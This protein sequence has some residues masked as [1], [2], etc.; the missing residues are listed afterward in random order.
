M[1][2]PTRL[3]RIPEREQV[4]RVPRSLGD[5]RFEVDA[6]WGTVGP[7]ELAPGVRTIGECEL[8][9]HLERGLPVMDTRQ[10]ELHREATIAGAHGIPHEEIVTRMGELDPSTP[11]VFFCNGPQCTATPHAVKALLEAG[12]PAE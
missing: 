9:E 2:T 6:T 12:F 1:R 10:A 3:E 11:T 8:I 5:G 7:I 4:F